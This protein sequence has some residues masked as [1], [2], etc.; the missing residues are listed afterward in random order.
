M[1]SK[2]GEQLAIQLLEANNIKVTDV[3]DNSIYWPQDIDLLC[4][5]DK[6]ISYSVEVKW[7][8]R[9]QKTGNMFI[10][11]LNTNSKGGKGWFNFTK[12]DFL[13]Y[14]DEGNNLFYVIPLEELRKWLAAH[15]GYYRIAEAFDYNR[16]GSIRGLSKGLLVPIEDV[17]SITRIINI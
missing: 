5:T 1:N 15:K 2:H 4:S 8:S 13:F 11:I 7:D 10:E 16:D 6:G 12:A 3:S 17:T 14:G 9:I